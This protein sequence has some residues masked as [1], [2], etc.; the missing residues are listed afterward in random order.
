MNMNI[1]NLNQKSSST[2]LAIVLFSML[3][4]AV[5][6]PAA[7][8]QATAVSTDKTSYQ[9]GQT[10]TISGTATPNAYVS[11]QVTD[12]KGTN[13]LLVT[14]KADS[15]GAYTRTFKLATNA[16]T[17]T[18]TISASQGG[19]I[20]TATFTV[21]ALAADTTP[22][23]LT[24]T[25]TP[26]KAEYGAE[27]ITIEIT[28][29]EDLKAAPTVTV[30]QSGA[31]AVPVT[32]SMVLTHAWHYQGTYAIMSGYDGTVTINVAAQDL[33][34]NAAT[35]TQTF[36][37]RV[38][39][40]VVD[41]KPVTDDL[42]SQITALK[43][44]V[45]SLQADVANLKSDVAALSAQTTMIPLAAIAIAIIAIAIAAAAIAMSRRKAPT[46]PPAAPAT[47]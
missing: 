7:I 42:Q 46:P 23:T 34:G 1:L 14:E 16:A 12:P 33:A 22:P 5:I 19:V 36:T 32:M 37:V 31:S 13:I 39:A 29:N 3:A 40:P 27:T 8:A 30:T 11:L 47:K 15:T 6:T 25:L 43:T 21:T 38:P 20:K 9:Q 45:T 44:Q 2:L 18:Y 28:A 4:L 10:V 17:G 41:W 35:A 24:I 26:V